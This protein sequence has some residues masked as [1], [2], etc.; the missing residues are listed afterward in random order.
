M[1]SHSFIHG[2]MYQFKTT[3]EIRLFSW[4][5]SD[6]NHKPFRPHL[7]ERTNRLTQCIYFNTENPW[8]GHALA[9]R[10]SGFVWC[11]W[12]TIWIKP[13]IW[14]YNPTGLALLLM[15][16]KGGVESTKKEPK[17]TKT[18][19][20]VTSSP[21]FIRSKYV[22]V[23][24]LN[25]H[26]FTVKSIPVFNRHFGCRH[27]FQTNKYHIKLVTAFIHWCTV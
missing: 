2:D 11:S 14:C 10:P 20:Y 23:L 24:P 22:Q 4:F 13:M 12:P 9:Q 21:M 18:K 3:P 5:A 16:Y 6:N 7:K 17:C 27:H 26:C 25:P 19:P 15:K 8:F 1:K